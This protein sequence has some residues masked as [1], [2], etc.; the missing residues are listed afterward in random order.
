ME[1]YQ[2]I[3]FVISNLLFIIVNYNVF[4]GCCNCIGKNKDSDETK[5]KGKNP[6]KT[7]GKSKP[8]LPN[9]HYNNGMGNS[10]QYNI[11]PHEYNRKV[12]IDTMKICNT[13]KYVQEAIKESIN[14]QSFITEKSNI[15]IKNG[16]SFNIKTNFNIK[17]EGNIEFQDKT[18]IKAA[19]YYLKQTGYKKKIAIL[20][21]A[22]WTDKGGGV[23]RGAVAQEEAICRCSTLYKNLIAD[24][25]SKFYESHNSKDNNNNCI[26]NDDIIYSPKVL[27]LKDDTD[28][29][30]ILTLD[31]NYEENKQNFV[32][33]IT[34]AA[35]YNYNGKIFTDKDIHKIHLSRGKRILD[36]ALNN[37]ID[38]IILGAFGCGA[39]KNNPIA[40]SKAYKE[41]L[42]NQNYQ[43]YFEKVVFAIPDKNHPNYKAFFATFNDTK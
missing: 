18:T 13:N 41:I 36:I 9:K 23:T 42:I 35:P 5:E 19:L 32:S 28:S 29:G 6:D 25:V 20:N 31:L 38:I 33:V 27:I 11:D 40:V 17:S 43:K 1:I 3:L 37:D 39:F 21:F 30:N 10:S 22:N 8:T 4:S 7:K 12:F 2:Y 26:C 34:C 14:V 24:N 15:Y 16:K